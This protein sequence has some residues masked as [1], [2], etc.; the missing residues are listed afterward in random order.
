[1]KG[2]RL[3]QYPHEVQNSV[4]PPREKNTTNARPLAGTVLFDKELYGYNKEQVDNYVSNLSKAYGEVFDAL[5]EFISK[6]DK[7]KKLNN[8]APEETKTDL[9][10]TIED[11]YADALKI[12]FNDSPA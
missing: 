10:K 6:E 3:M 5:A 9:Q 1:M 4:F 2:G 8:R 7:N 12:R 11:F